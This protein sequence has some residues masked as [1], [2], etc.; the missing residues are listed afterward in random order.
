ME[1]HGKH[2]G[3]GEEMKTVKPQGVILDMDGVITKTARIHRESW[4]EMFNTYLAATKA[5][6]SPMT[7]NDYLRYIDGKPRYEGV[8][9]FLESRNIHLPFGNPDEPANEKT[10]CGL[11]NL[12]NT[13]FL[14]LL[15][16]KGVE[17]YTNAIEQIK[18]WRSAGLKTAVVSSSR[19]CRK[20]L[21][22]AGI[23]DLFNSRVDGMSI[24]ERDLKG[25]PAPDMFLEAAKE[26]GK[27]PF[28]CA[29]F[30][31]SIS[32]VQAGS[33]GNFALVV[34]VDRGGNLKALSENG[35]DIVVDNLREIDLFD[36]GILK[37]FVRFAPSL[38][39]KLSEFNSLIRDKKPILFLDYDGTL[40]PIVKK[41]EEAILSDA[42]KEVL[43]KY[44]AKSPVAVISGRDMDDLKNMIGIDTLIYGGSHGFR[45]SGPDGLHLEFG[46]SEDIPGQLDRIE[47]KLKGLFTTKKIR[48]VQIERKRYAIAVHY[49]NVAR[50]EADAVVRD[51]EVIIG[52]SPGFRKGEGKMIIEVRPDVDWHKGRAIA[53]ILE[54]LGLSDNP[55]VIPIYIGDDITDE[56]VFRTLPRNGI[57]ILVGFH[58]K[59]TKARYSLK[60]VYQVR[61]FIEM[62]TGKNNS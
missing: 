18:Y 14:D 11:G 61:I 13:L 25:K 38:F 28:Q 22:S 62:L 60:N 8:R 32:G 52:Q 27:D 50:E 9:S 31:D 58:G 20:V 49:R 53:W 39:L 21:E 55:D 7:D 10:V 56:D 1:T 3:Q 17:T 33:R 54:K 15:E 5:S 26:I 6:Q 59:P 2:T 35:S 42:M 41:P 51:V 4:K 48:G 16:R 40:T 44:N 47:I 24:I 43:R 46:G 36:P 34:G 45:I 29:V 30:E 37:Y 12:K 19:N 23:S 57:G